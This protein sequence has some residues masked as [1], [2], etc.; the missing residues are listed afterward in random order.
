[1]GCQRNFE[2]SELFIYGDKRY[3]ANP[4]KNPP[5]TIATPWHVFWVDFFFINLLLLLTV[6]CISLWCIEEYTA[7]RA[8]RTVPFIFN[9][10]LTVHRAWYIRI[11]WTNRCII[12]YKFIS[13]VSLYMFPAGLL[14]IIRG[15][16][17][18]INSSWYSHALCWLAAGRIG[19]DPPDDEQQAW[20]KH[21]EAYYWSKLI[22]NSASCWF[23]L[24]WL[25]LMFVMCTEFHVAR[26]QTKFCRRYPHRMKY[27]SGQI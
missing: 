21:V 7:K 19:R 16:Q 8:I 2:N 27:W 20:S 24:Y 14:L 12:F 5:L 26:M 22:E 10:L 13:I 23:V 15:D 3:I 1:M 4:L 11:T 17:L 25:H 6:C 18:C 9:V